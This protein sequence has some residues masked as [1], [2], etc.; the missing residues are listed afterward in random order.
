MT[1]AGMPTTP[2]GRA[3]E[4]WEY[5][6]IRLNVDTLFGPD[7][8]PDSLRETLDA[9]GQDGWE[10]VNSIAITRGNGRTSELVFLF[11][12][13]YRANRYVQSS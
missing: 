6:V 4:H 1:S 9:V 8:D 2:L 13:P 10:L 11:K 12:R 3:P 5:H 7:I